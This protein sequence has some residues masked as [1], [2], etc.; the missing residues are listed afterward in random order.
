MAQ[1]RFFQKLAI[2][3]ANADAIISDVKASSLG[4]GPPASLLY[5][6]GPGYS[7]SFALS[8]LEQATWLSSINPDY[9]LTYPSN[10]SSLLDVFEQ[11]GDV[12][13]ALK[14]IRCIG[15]TVT[16]G[17]RKRVEALNI[18]LSDVYS[19][20]EVGVI[21]IQC[22][23][24]NLYHLQSESLLVEVLDDDN[25]ACREGQIGRVVITDLYNFLMP[26]IRYEILDYAEVGGA[27]PCGRGLPTVSEILGRRRNMLSLPDGSKR[28]PTVGFLR[29]KEI[30]P[31]S[32]Y[33]VI[34]HSLQDIEVKLVVSPKLTAE[35]EQSLAKIVQTGL[36]HPFSI[37]F[38]YYDSEFEQTR[39]GKFEEFISYV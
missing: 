19:S 15:E 38:S 17:L 7:Q 21:A 16:E 39:S 37:R 31:I 25:R 4:W 26:L 10:L 34:Q 11:R 6:T 1:T 2:I 20:Q 35:Q 5:S 12:P 32:Q 14:E 22:P 36:G 3:R 23:S 18:K 28:W 27:C 8:N 24:S 30:A 33:Q 29:F 13:K 9:L